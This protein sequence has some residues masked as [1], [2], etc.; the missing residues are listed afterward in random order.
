MLR[1]LLCALA[2]P[3]LA[4]ATCTR[5]T[6]VVLIGDSI[7]EGVISEPVGPSY[8]ALL[9]ESLGP[10]FEVVNLGCGGTSSL[11]WTRS[12]GGVLC[13]T[14]RAEPNLYEALARPR[15]PADLVTI[16]L[17]T[18]DAMGFSEE[19]RIEPAAFRAAI[20]ELVKD[21]RSD[22]ARQILLM[23]PPPHYP[24]FGT[25]RR[26]FDYR[27]QIQSLCGAPDDAV[28]C[29]PDI[30][31]LLQPDDFQDGN[32]HP[33]AYGQAKIASALHD[34]ILAAVGSPR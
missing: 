17:G 12:R 18:N 27:S 13:G 8:A 34:A 32:V 9:A 19:Q 7:T 33:N 24:H 21:L 16:L 6:S 4:G 3:L 14:R 26:V 23:T 29:G 20:E 2:L 28:L 22:G 10:G 15:L 5:P 25:Q 11:D 1:R 31:A 30:F